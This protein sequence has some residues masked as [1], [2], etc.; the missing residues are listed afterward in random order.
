[1]AIHAT[2]R[3]RPLGIAYRA[4]LLVESKLLIE[5]KATDAI[6][7]A[8]VAQTLSYLRLLGLRLGLLINFSAPL[9]KHGIK[10]VVNNL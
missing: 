8:H 7:D 3:D 10:R 4:D 2:Y 1:M 6:H 5:V 9:I